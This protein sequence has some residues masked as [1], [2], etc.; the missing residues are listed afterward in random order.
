MF[1]EQA[2]QGQV[3]ILTIGTI[4][5]STPSYA[6]RFSLLFNKFSLDAYCA[7]DMV[8]GAG[9]SFTKLTKSLLSGS[10]QARANNK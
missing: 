1:S 3:G 7:L 10:F 2:D 8:L 4:I 6:F 9:E 5:F